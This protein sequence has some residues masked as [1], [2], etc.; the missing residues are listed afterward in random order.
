MSFDYAVLAYINDGTATRDAVAIVATTINGP[1]FALT[2]TQ[3][4]EAMENGARAVAAIAQLA[5]MCGAGIRT[6]VHDNPEA[7]T[8]ML[9]SIA[10][11]GHLAQGDDG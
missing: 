5:T 11:G 10:L 3:I 8:R 9:Q 6:I 4:C 1:D 2:V 7:A